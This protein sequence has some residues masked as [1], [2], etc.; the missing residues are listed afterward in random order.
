MVKMKDIARHLGIS[1]STAYKAF[2]GASD[3]NSETRTMIMEA[4]AELGYS[5]S[6]RKSA[7]KRV[8][9]F[10]GHM[11]ANYTTS[12]NY[13]IAIAFMQT[14]S[15]NGCEVLVRELTEKDIGDFNGVMSRF[16]FEG[17]LVLGLDTETKIYAQMDKIVYPAVV[18]DNYIN[19]PKITNITVDNL[20]GMSAIVEY[21][22]DLGHKYIG[23]ISAGPTSMAGKERFAGYLNT[24]T[25]RGLQYRPDYV[26]YGDFSESSGADKVEDLVGAHRNITAIA[27]GSDLMAIGAIRC[28]NK[29][30]LRVPEDISVTGFDDVRLSR[31]ITPALTTMRVNVKEVGFRAFVCL[32]DMLERNS[33][34]TH[35]VEAPS[36]VIRNSAGPVPVRSQP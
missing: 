3:I 31:Y 17:C 8:C 33:T 13:E 19:S 28:L 34:P 26:R 29:L 11:E 24:I 14:A 4:A 30:G 25:L 27:C 1:V 15:Q 36:L 22:C 20:N 32:S 21:L 16:G 18:T 7:G 10:I 6:Q 12:Y 23:L 2:N 35:V 5:G 9:V